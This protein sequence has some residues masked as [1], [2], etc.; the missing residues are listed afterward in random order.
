MSFAGAATGA[1]TA[2]AT[3]G[4]GTRARREVASLSQQELHDRLARLDASMGFVQRAPIAWAP[5]KDGVEAVDAELFRA[6][7]RSLLLTSSVNDLPEPDRRRP[8]V[9]ARLQAG[10]PEADYA[11]FGSMAR[12][13]QMSPAELDDVQQALREDP[14]LPKKIAEAIDEEA[15]SGGVPLRRRLH[16]R[17]MTSHVLWRMKRQSVGLILEETLAKVD[18]LAKRVLRSGELRAVMQPRPEDVLY[19]E[20]RATRVVARHDTPM[21]YGLGMLARM[22]TP[23]GTVPAP[24][25]PAQAPAPAPAQAPAPAPAPTPAQPQATTPPPSQPTP[26]SQPPEEW[27]VSA[28]GEEEEKPGR[29]R[30]PVEPADDAGRRLMVVGGAV[31]GTSVGLALLGV[32]LYFTTIIG[33]LVAWTVAGILLIVGIILMIVGAVR[34]GEPSV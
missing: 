17:R 27:G 10:A 2:C 31:I 25:P 23:T 18:R 16:L 28:T 13:S 9:M 12:V 3:T 26:P 7:M 34:R 19:W 14:E 4:T 32:L 8:E 6:S 33:G 30:P 15:R 5:A 24:P 20:A 11:V 22:Q 29:A 21:S 1:S